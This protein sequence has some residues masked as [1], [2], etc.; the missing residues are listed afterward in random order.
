MQVQTI[1]SEETVIIKYHSY[2]YVM[3]PSRLVA[4]VANN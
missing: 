3:L 1:R 4:D 2:N